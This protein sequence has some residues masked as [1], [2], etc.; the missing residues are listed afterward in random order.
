MAAIE[1]VG[2]EGRQQS[3]RRGGE[4]RC[5]DGTKCDDNEEYVQIGEMAGRS[6]SVM[7]RERESCAT[8]C[9]WR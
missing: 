3:M 9:R 8:H 5:I 2:F 4:G 6:E 1:S 7:S